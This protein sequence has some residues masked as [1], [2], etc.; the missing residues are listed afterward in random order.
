VPGSRRS[1]PLPSGWGAIRYAVLVRDPTCRWGA[2]GIPNEDD[3]CGQPST[4]VD[5]IGEPSDHRPS[6]LRGICYS[7]HLKRSS[8]QGNAVLSAR[9]A[10]SVRPKERHPGYIKDASAQ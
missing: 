7:H 6:V 10:L 9:R 5:H 8:A 2:V 4:E 3:R 1:V